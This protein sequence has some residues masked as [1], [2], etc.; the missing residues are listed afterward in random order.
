MFLLQTEIAFVHTSKRVLIICSWICL[1]CFLN[2]AHWFSDRVTV[3]QFTGDKD[4]K[5]WP[6]PNKVII[7]LQKIRNKLLLTHIDINHMWHIKWHIDIFIYTFIVLLS[8]SKLKIINE[9]SFIVIKCKSVTWTVF[10]WRTKVWVWN[11]PSLWS[12]LQLILIVYFLL[13]RG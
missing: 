6:V 3:V 9:F 2:S 12:D 10:S 13:N 5:F 7:G 8:L 11:G 1:S 4:K